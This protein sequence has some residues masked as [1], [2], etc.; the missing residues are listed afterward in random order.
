MMTVV[1]PKEFPMVLLAGAILCLECFAIGM[2]VCVP[3]RLKVFT[4][5]FMA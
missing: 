3:A 4:K 1:L 5:E 2:I